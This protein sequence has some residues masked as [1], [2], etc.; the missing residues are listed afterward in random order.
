PGSIELSAVWSAVP[1]TLYFFRGPRSYTGQDLAE[2][3]TTGS[4][5]LVERLVADLLAAGARPANPGEFTLR[6][7]LAGE[8]DLPQAEAVHAV[9]EAGADAA[10]RTALAQLARGVTLPLE[11]LRNGLRNL[12]AARECVK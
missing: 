5:P 4:P 3:H 11:A 9:I 2:L 1:A 7:F 12:L 10:L 6:A 8:K